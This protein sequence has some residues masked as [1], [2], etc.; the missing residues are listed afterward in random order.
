MR[1]SARPGAF[2][3]QQMTTAAEDRLVTG[4]RTA[5]ARKAA[6]LALDIGLSA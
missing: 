1:S 6:I 5:V 2:T 4:P 3:R